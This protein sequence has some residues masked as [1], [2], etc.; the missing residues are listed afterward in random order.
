MKN[1]FIILFILLV[2]AIPFQLR[3]SGDKIDSLRQVIASHP[4]GE[5]LVDA[6]LAMD[7]EYYNIR[8]LDSMKI[9]ADSALKIST[10]IHY[11][12]GITK[13]NL[14]L[15][16]YYRINGQL[17]NAMAI[18][19][20]LLYSAKKLG[21]DELLGKTYYN[22]AVVY[23]L[24]GLRDSAIY[25]VKASLALNLQ[26]TST[27]ILNY[28]GLGNIFL[29]ISENDSSLY[30][31]FKA[32]KLAEAKD[33][34]KLGLIYGNIGKVYVFLLGDDE[35]D[36]Y[37]KLAIEFAR[38]YKDYKTVA[39]NLSRLSAAYYTNKDYDEALS[40]LDKASA[41]LDSNGDFSQ[42]TDQYKRYGLIYEA[43][44]K[45]DLALEYYNKAIESAEAEYDYKGMISGLHVIGLFYTDLGKHELARIYLDSA[46][47]IIHKIG[48]PSMEKLILQLM[49]RNSYGA[50]KYKQAY[51]EHEAFFR[52]YDSLDNVEKTTIV[53]EMKVKYE[54]EKDQ[55]QI[56]SLEKE[57]LKRK[58]QRNLV[59]FNSSALIVAALFFLV[60]L[61][62]KLLKTRLISQQKILKLEEEKKIMLARNLVEG[63]EE[64]RKRIAMELHDGLGVILSATRMQFS[65]INGHASKDPNVVKKAMQLLD[66]ATGE[67][68]RISHNMMPGLLTKLGLYEAIED[69]FET[70]NET[71]GLKAEF[72]YSEDIPRLPEN[73]EIMMYRIIQEMVNNTIKYA[74]ARRIDL[75]LTVSGAELIIMYRD[76]GQGFA[77]GEAF[78]AGNK[79]LGLKSI[80]SRVG[81]LNG[82]MSL[83]SELGKEVHYMIRVPV[84]HNQD[85]SVSS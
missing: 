66:Q 20:E 45:Y 33:P 54:K 1:R 44:G 11:I 74:N 41:L 19:P 16:L 46:M 47:K 14:S 4:S 55:A 34:A 26:D 49:A 8:K 48:Y 18:V 40:Y 72:T 62:H 12:K 32:A 71:E 39:S 35:A 77:I 53:T 25:F 69:L 73:A 38:K 68:R 70:L 42:R 64:E 85:I 21:D 67:V 13:S 10:S 82:E 31:Y 17:N 27:I 22:I 61:R 28:I 9:Y 23:A 7:K 36:K 29:D 30:Y 50:R 37:Y 65:I 6:L 15:C 84:N 80:E 5:E 76:N 79:S 59:L 56:L 63:Q 51:E 57:S 60:I 3:A 78:R 81:F 75:S 43:Q 58:L 83:N 24:T 52:M 2:T